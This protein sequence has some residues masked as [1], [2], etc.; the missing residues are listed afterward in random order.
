MGN[1]CHSCDK[2]A[3]DFVMHINGYDQLK[4]SSANAIPL[5]VCFCAAESV[6]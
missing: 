2:T 4:I 3:A 5:Q 1:L 6:K